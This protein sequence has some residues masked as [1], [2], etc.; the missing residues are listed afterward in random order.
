MVLPVPFRAAVLD[1][2]YRLQITP[3]ASEAE[4][5]EVGRRAMD[6]WPRGARRTESAWLGA[7][8]RNR[9][10]YHV[11]WVE[12]SARPLERGLLW[13]VE[14]AGTELVSAA[15]QG[16]GHSFLPHWCKVALARLL[17]EFNDGLRRWDPASLPRLRP[18][19]DAWRYIEGVGPPRTLRL[20]DFYPE[21][22][23]APD[24][25][26]HLRDL[27]MI[28]WRAAGW[29]GERPD[30]RHQAFLDLSRALF[31]V[32]GLS[33]HWLLRALPKN[34]DRREDVVL[35]LNGAPSGLQIRTLRAMWAWCDR[36]ML[37]AKLWA[38]VRETPHPVLR[39][40][41]GTNW[42][43]WSDQGGGMPRLL[44]EL[45]DDI[46]GTLI[47]SIDVAR[48]VSDLMVELLDLGPLVD[49]PVL[50]DEALAAL[51]A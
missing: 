19:Q 5:D 51:P 48:R 30:W 29:P 46:A 13:A 14:Q 6:H 27:P 43:G 4:I 24:E 32:N 50:V 3:L 26:V 7:R 31:L 47:D 2:R 18:R 40:P 41:G 36:L 42:D 17:V 39:G 20:D 34:V 10:T 28:L 25:V 21:D 37:P 33:D 22:A 38:G 23:P 9:G 16:L 1:A 11:S 12:G 15:M 49:E 45:G 35:A 44:A 8:A